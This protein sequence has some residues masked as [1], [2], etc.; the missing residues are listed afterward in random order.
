MTVHPGSCHCGGVRFTI[1]HEPDE[2]TTCD[3]SL[4]VKRNAVMVKV[5]EAA[6]RIEAGADLLATYQWNT[7]RAT[8]HFC[9]R[10]G[11]YL[12]HRKRAAPDQYGVNVFCLDGF[13]AAALPIRATDGIGMSLVGESPRVE[14]PGPRGGAAST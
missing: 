9:S 5:P 13:D 8:H 12:F 11:I 2:V 3:C 6:L 7:M 14:W 10:C 1:A 4:C